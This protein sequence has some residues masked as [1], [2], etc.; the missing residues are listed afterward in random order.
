M[1]AFLAATLVLGLLYGGVMSLLESQTAAVVEAE[2]RG[3]VEDYEVSG[4]RGLRDAIARRTSTRNQP[5]A[6]YVFAFA[7]GRP[8]AGNLS[9]FP[10]TQLDGSWQT[11]DLLRT[12]IDREVTVGGRAF[13]LPGSRML[14]VGRDL[15]EQREFR[16]LFIQLSIGMLGLFL[17]TGGIGG[18]LV[19]RTILKRVEEIENVAADI[20]GGKLERRAPDRGTADEF[21]RLSASLNKM[22]D[23]NEDLVGELRTVTDS[24][25]HDLR[26]PLARLRT[27]VDEIAADDPKLSEKVEAA[28]HE[29]KY[30][31]SVFSALIDISRLQSGLP[32]DQFRLVDLRQ[33]A[34]DA[35]DLYEPL[36]ES[37][38]LKLTCTLPAEAH[39]EG[40]G[41]FLSQAL[42][43]LLDNAVKHSPTGGDIELGVTVEKDTARLWVSDQGPGIQP[44]DWGKAVQRFGRLDTARTTRGMGLGLSMVETIAKLH[45]GSLHA[46]KT[47]GKFTVEL[48]IPVSSQ[49]NTRP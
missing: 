7:S 39:A 19:S 38:G 16:Q 30:V 3:L 11:I 35:A 5:D 15:R 41:Q 37:N 32:S 29:I 13:L 20:R 44:Q 25:S 1:S 23:T 47:D 28:E 34:L 43:N 31:Q 49:T 24:L 4:Q 33:I 2:L 9:R 42:T 45:G 17:L 48:N 27:I 18:Y 6:V 46:T 12:D 8:I 36:A 22:L 14:F 26:T 21:D 10:T 40:H